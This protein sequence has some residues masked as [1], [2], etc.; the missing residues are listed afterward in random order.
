MRRATAGLFASL[1]AV[2]VV[3]F[4]ATRAATTSIPPLPLAALRFDVVAAVTSVV[5]S[6]NPTLVAVGYLLIKRRTI[7]A[8]EVENA[9][10]TGGDGRVTPVTTSRRR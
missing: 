9:L 7:R 5:V 4:V 10:D 1:A 8:V 2:W 6:L 3:S